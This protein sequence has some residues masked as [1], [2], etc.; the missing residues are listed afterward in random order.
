MKRG[1]K[2]NQLKGDVRVSFSKNQEDFGAGF[3]EEFA[4]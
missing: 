3:A 4:K 1:S 2:L